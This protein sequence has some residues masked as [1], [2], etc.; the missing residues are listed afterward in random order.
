VTSVARILISARLVGRELLRNRAAVALLL[1]VPTVFYM[2][3]SITSGDRE[4]PFRLSA[5]GGMLSA[6]ERHVAVLFIGL[7]SV[8]GLSAFLAFTLVFRAAEADRRLVFEGYRPAELLAAK[9]LVLAAAS[10]VV[11]AYVTLI[12][13]LFFAP[14]RVAA[15]FPGFVLTAV[16]YALVGMGIGAVVRRELE[17]ILVVLLLVNIDA[18]W[19]QSPVYYASARNAHVIRMLPGHHPSQVAMAGAFSEAE[20]RKPLVASA[21]YAAGLAAVVALLYRR[22]VTVSR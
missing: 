21:A 7:A 12:L 19:L 20:L 14:E 18:G 17:G 11:S 10:A 6:P 9:W 13:P 4:I 22:A 16:V 5:V 1:V 15:V 2:L 8:S 3:V